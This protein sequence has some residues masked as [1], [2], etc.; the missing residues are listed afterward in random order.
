MKND[1]PLS[2]SQVGAQL[3]LSAK[4]VRTL[5]RVGELPAFR[6]GIRNLK[7]MQS[8]V[9]EFKARRT[10]ALRYENDQKDME[11]VHKHLSLK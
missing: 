2:I 3:G 9:D 8:D 4:T 1:E 11:L 5:I 6:P 10:R 7:V